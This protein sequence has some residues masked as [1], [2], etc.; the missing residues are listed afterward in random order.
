MPRKIRSNAYLYPFIVPR[1]NMKQHGIPMEIGKI[2]KQGLSPSL[3][4]GKLINRGL[5]GLL[6]RRFD[7]TTY[8]TADYADYAD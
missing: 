3:R 5:R 1:L 8:L 2:M 7:R 6:A 4:S